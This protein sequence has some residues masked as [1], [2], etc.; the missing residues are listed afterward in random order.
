MATV[1]IPPGLR[2]S[3]D[4]E[5]I[6]VVTFSR[7]GTPGWGCTVAGLVVAGLVWMG[8]VSWLL[9]GSG[10]PAGAGVVFAVL[11]TM[12]GL[13]PM[14]VVAF[15]LGERWIYSFGADT[16]TIERRMGPI[17]RVS[18]LSRGAVAGVVQHDL[19][20]SRRRQTRLWPLEVRLASEAE[21]RAPFLPMQDFPA[22]TWFGTYLAEWAGVAF[23]EAL[24]KPVGPSPGLAAFQATSRSLKWLVPLVVL[25]GL[26]LVMLSRSGR[27]EV[28]SFLLEPT[29]RHNRVLAVKLLRF[30]R[31]D[32]SVLVLVRLLNT[33]SVEADAGVAETALGSLAAIAGQPFARTGELQWSQAIG[34]ANRWA[35][36]RLGR[37]LDGNAGVLGW[38]PVEEGFA[39]RVGSIGSASPQ[40]GCDNL[41]WFGPVMFSTAEE[42]LKRAGAAL[43]DGRPISF[44]LVRDGN[45]LECKPERLAD[46]EGQPLAR[47]VGEALALKLWEFRGV[48]SERFPD[49]FHSWWAAYARGRHFPPPAR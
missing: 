4:L 30:D 22:S 43:G 49:D 27:T 20:P 46:S 16:L 34:E 14:A 11:V 2:V 10:Q 1:Q 12:G 39:S 32:V 8:A 37:S 26:S 18:T 47:T 38:F 29:F 42:F 21:G 44:G 9:V 31:S 17:R 7:R 19:A 41:F 33:V 24:T 6:P 5:G 13:L 15:R 23:T 35:A 40:D 25:G 36:G 3:A 28:Y 45:Q 48:G